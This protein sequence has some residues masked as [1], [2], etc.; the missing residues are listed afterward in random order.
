M[1]LYLCEKPSQAR[2]IARVL[3]VKQRGQGC[4]LNQNVTVTWAIGHLLEMAAPEHYGEQFGPPWRMEPLPVLPA[5]WQ[6]TVKKETA[7]QFA[8]IKQL[9]KQAD[10]VII[11]TDADREG[12]VIA[13]ELLEYCGF[14]GP[15]SRLWL[16]ALDETSIRQ[17]LAALLPGEQTEPLYQAG[18]GRARA[19]WLMGINLT[20]LYTLKAQA[21]GFGEVLSIG[22]V[23][24]PTLALVVNRDNVI[25]RFEP[26]PFWQVMAT[27]QK[28]NVAFRAKWL[29]APDVCDGEKRCSRE[30]IAHRVVKT[31][32]QTQ[33]AVVTEIIRKRE[34]T[35]PPLCFDLGTLQQVASRQWGMGAGQVLTIAQSLYETHKATTYPRTDCGYL[36]VSMR[37]DIPA[38]FTALTR[39]DPAMSGIISQLD[40][41]MLSRVWNDS[42]ITA[43]HAIIPTRHTFDMTK[44]TADE[45]KVYQLIRQYYLAQFLPAQETDVTEVTLNIGGQ[46]FQA[47][48]RVSVATGWKALFAREQDEKQEEK[49][50]ENTVLPE[51]KKEET[52][53]VN[54]A[55][56][57]PRQ[58][59]PPA[60][61]TEGTLIA[62]MKNAA[63]FIHDPQLKKV[64]RESSGLGTEATRAGIIEA[65]FKRQLLV[66]KKKNL[67]ATQLA[68][69]LIAGLPDVL[70]H[71]GMTA[72]WE[73]SLDD[74]AQ[75]RA[76][77]DDFMQKQTQW[78][79]HLMEKGKAQPIQFTL[80]KTPVC[81]RCG[82]TMQKRMGKTTPF[83]GCTRYPACKGML[84]ASAVTGSR[85]TRRGN[86]SA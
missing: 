1:Q 59:R 18:L 65:L 84:N 62:A 16:S 75:G 82:G 39:T 73:Q 78:L 35:P 71:P 12:E 47:R 29:P 61:F 57:Q 8:V 54:G 28:D 27:L 2:D 80:P 76:T 52:C 70:T 33:H 68:Q 86:S 4:L 72:L 38:V 83:W 10:E 48:G 50:D 19:D 46:L 44:L 63:A 6:W 43:H 36:P 14:I 9:L 17:A 32:Q 51:L 24:T 79:A 15:V 23:Q 40:A 3:G 69:E 37:A 7:D 66:R 53:Q 21:Q 31:C 22:R 58:T 13:R 34:K 81:P 77:L 74:I 41:S 85:K 56:I 49:P 5:Q 45:L 25:S 60:P 11:A 64:L 26:K 67:H 30:D 42:Q 20:R 55:E